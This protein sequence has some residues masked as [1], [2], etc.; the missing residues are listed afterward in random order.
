M[1]AVE[2][3]IEAPGHVGEALE[4]LLVDQRVVD[5]P[6]LLEVMSQCYDLPI[7]TLTPEILDVSQAS[8]IPHHILKEYLI[9]PLQ[10]PAG[11]E[12]IPLAVCDP[13]DVVAQDT[14]RLITG[15][16][17]ELH[18]A[19]QG[20][21]ENAIAGRLMS[22]EGFRILAE[23]LPEGEQLDGLDAILESTSELSEN[24][25]PIIKLVNSILRDA[26]HR[27]ASDIHLEPQETF[28]GVRYR[29]DGI[30][31]PV[32]EM[33][34]RVEKTCISRVKIM[35]GIDISESRKPQ[36]GRLSLRVA[37]NKVNMR[38]S[39]VPGFFGE[40]VVMRILD[41]SAVKLD[42]PNLGL[43]PES[44]AVLQSHLASS[45]G[46]VLITGPTGSG[47]TSTLYASLR[48]LNRTSVNIVTVEDPIEYQVP[49][50]TQVAVNNRAGVTF[51]SSLRAFL[52]QDPDIIMVGEVRDL[53]TAE[54]AIQAAQTGHLVFSTLH[55]NDSPS[56]L[57]RLVLMG[58]E[59]HLIAD[60]LLCVVAQRLVRRLCPHCKVGGPIKPEHQILLS[61]S[62][63]GPEISQVFHP[64]GCEE[65]HGTGYQGR[66]GLYEILTL[67][68]SIRQQM[69]IDT[70]ENALWEAARREGMK[71]LLEDGVSKVEDGLTSLDEVLRVV[72]I[73]RRPAGSTTG[74]DKPRPRLSPSGR[75]VRE[76]MSRQLVTVAPDTL[77]SE[78][79]QLALQKSLNG[80]PVLSSRGELIGVIT[81]SDLVGARYRHPQSRQPQTV[82]EV[83]SDKP[84]TVEAEESLETA[85]TVFRRRRVH[86]LL[87][88]EGS[89]LVGVVTPF[90]L[91]Q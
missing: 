77:L 84:I 11:S 2:Q 65:C 63:E 17:V 64:V 78:V 1:E 62:V 12:V 90:D 27:K 66:L 80:F 81:V 26:I 82:R 31:H 48:L 13:F 7:V 83:M 37:G 40:K 47:K 42:L 50:L 18:L 15:R 61:L 70:S 85:A 54:T 57:S 14:V 3:A 5:E 21:L 53:E 79:G 72:T 44:L 59:P 67:T 76:V 56:T 86:R 41:Q 20:E 46:M 16:E 88:T 52:R 10:R 33:P 25:A 68:S 19:A 29:I 60:S 24:D 55:T 22:S 75:T 43:R 91:M 49:G 87:V 38:V 9:Y 39:T 8:L 32:V 30:L 58:V 74:T 6:T 36:D 71:S 28:F 51:A 34:R 45:S 89:R 69:L 23:D 35:S 4:R 73:R